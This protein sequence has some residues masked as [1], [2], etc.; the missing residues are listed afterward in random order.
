[1]HQSI[2]RSHF[3]FQMTCFGLV[4]CHLIQLK[5]DKNG[6]INNRNWTNN[7]SKNK[8]NLERT[9]CGSWPKS[10]YLRICFAIGR[11]TPKIQIL[12]LCLALSTKF[13][14]PKTINT[15]QMTLTSD[16]E[17][18]KY[19]LLFRCSSSRELSFTLSTS[20]RFPYIFEY[21]FKKKWY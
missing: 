8:T 14:P 16:L 3:Q 6:T 21:L 18:S 2:R 9:D 1:M 17:S 10:R 19:L 12:G 11:R 4:P 5:N 15:L 7:K 13:M 20:S